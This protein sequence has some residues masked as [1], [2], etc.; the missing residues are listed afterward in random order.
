[1]I[2]NDEMKRVC[3]SFATIASLGALSGCMSAPEVDPSVVLMDQ[4]AAEITEGDLAASF[5]PAQQIEPV[6]DSCIA[7]LDCPLPATL[8]ALPDLVR[9]AAIQSPGVL[10]AQAQVIE[11]RYELGAARWAFFPEPSVSTSLD[12]EGEASYS[13]GL[14]QPVY[15][16]GRLRSDLT[17]ATARL[18]MAQNRLRLAQHE[19]VQNV[20]DAYGGWMSAWIRESAW[21]AGLVEHD[22]ILELLR[23]RVAAGATG[24][25]EL[26]MAQSRRDSVH[27]EVLAAQAARA[28]TLA[29]LT[30]AVGR[31]LV[32][33]ELADNL[34]EARPVLS[35]RLSARQ[36]ALANSP[37]LAIS[38]AEIAL[39]E[40]V[41]Q[42]A[43]SALFPA[44]SFEVGYGTDSDGERDTRAT[45]GLRSNFGPGLSVAS[46]IGRAAAGREVAMRKRAVQERAVIE[47]V[48][49]TLAL[50]ETSQQRLLAL[51]AVTEAARNTAQSY[52]RQFENGSRNWQD[53]MSAAREIASN[54]ANA[55]DAEST[56]VGSSWKLFLL[57][58]GVYSL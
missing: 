29:R 32:E 33:T 58:E 3:K 52:Q 48:E 4:S 49:S 53:L 12:E 2:A 31:S 17:Q 36:K 47:Q 10:Q 46:E 21:S 38:D 23:R 5:L 55:A 14:S 6:A 27:S 25:N 35:D 28:T 56:V 7:R 51:R 16:G 19:S 41:A 1:M 40:A 15:R 20:L 39:S 42:S 22:G 9:M 11:A 30:Q 45:L 24:E 37:N 13:V 34:A 57:V 50:F 18:E 26:V 43:R 44:V 8:G 54:G